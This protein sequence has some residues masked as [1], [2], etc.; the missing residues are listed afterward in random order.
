MLITSHDTDTFLAYVKI[1]HFVVG[2]NFLFLDWFWFYGD[3]L[4]RFALHTHFSQERDGF[5]HI[6]FY[7]TILVVLSLLEN[8][9]DHSSKY[10]FS[11]FFF[12]APFG[13][14]MSVH[15]CQINS[16]IVGYCCLCVVL[17]THLFDHFFLFSLSTHQQYSFDGIKLTII[18][19][20]LSPI[21]W[22]KK[23][24]KNCFQFFFC[25]LS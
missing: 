21:N 24:V 1:N 22:W 7:L 19:D 5:L 10:F 6:F 11:L 9:M 4:I 15:L 8:V 23:F 12:F 16:N 3:S 17:E 25:F 13:T 14:H 2:F 20:E 18:D